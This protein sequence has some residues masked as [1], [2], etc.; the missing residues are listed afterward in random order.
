MSRSLQ[1][2][3]KKQQRAACNRQSKSSS[4]AGFDKKGKSQQR[5]GGGASQPN[6]G[7]APGCRH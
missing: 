3:Q 1:A 6:R 7:G 2:E 4:R 5:A